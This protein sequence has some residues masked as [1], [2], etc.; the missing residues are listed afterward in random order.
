MN[1]WFIQ[2]LALLVALTWAVQGSSDTPDSPAALDSELADLVKKVEKYYA[3]VSDFSA[4][5]RQKL[6]RIHLPHRPLEKTGK[7]YFKR[8]G[9]MR[10]D[11]EKPEKIHYVSDGSFLWNYIPESQLVYRLPV[12]DSELFYALQ[13]LWG[14]GRLDQEFVP[15]QGKKEG[16][17]QTLILAPRGGHQ[18]FQ[19]LRLLVDPDSG[20]IHATIMVDPAGNIS[21]LDFLR[22]SYKTLP[23]GGFEFTPPSGVEIIEPGQEP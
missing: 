12:A 4:R 3:E 11:Y 20:R 1:R 18:H 10:W 17:Y 15:S 2:G 14:Q 7:V 9:K 13:F 6:Q 21:R 8:P 5:F 22:V 23:D 16:E 19:E